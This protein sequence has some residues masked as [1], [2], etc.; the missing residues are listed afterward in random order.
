MNDPVKS[1]EEEEAD[2]SPV[3]C[4]AFVRARLN[5]V[6][7]AMMLRAE[8][9]LEEIIGALADEKERYVNRIMELESIAP[10]KVVMPDGKVM[11]WQCPVE[12]VPPCMPNDQVEVHP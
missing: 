12:L 7:V 1:N 9:P 2:S 10:R 3:P 8:R 5:D 11:L 4:S 6:T